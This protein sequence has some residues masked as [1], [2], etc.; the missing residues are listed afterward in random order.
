MRA[1]CAAT[2]ALKYKLR[3]IRATFTKFG[4]DLAS[5]DEFGLKIP[6]NF[7]QTLDFNPK[8]NSNDI[9]EIIEGS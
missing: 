1:S 2:F 4:K 7:K 8:S 3:T 9:A 5:E 6:N